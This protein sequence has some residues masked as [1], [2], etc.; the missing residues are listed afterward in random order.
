MGLVYLF[1]G[2]IW[3]GSMAYNYK[4]LLR[5]QFW[6]AAVI[7]LGISNRPLKSKNTVLY[8]K[9]IDFERND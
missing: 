9:L 8:L 5:L 1:I 7:F 4:D 6:L 3:L 2:M